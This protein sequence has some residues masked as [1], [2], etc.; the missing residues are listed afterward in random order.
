MSIAAKIILLYSLSFAVALFYGHRGPCLSLMALLTHAVPA[1]PLEAVVLG[2]VAVVAG[3]AGHLAAGLER[4][5]R[6][7]RRCRPVVHL[8]LLEP[9]VYRV[10]GYG[11]DVVDH[12]EACRQPR[13]ARR[14]EVPEP[15]R[16]SV[17]RPGRA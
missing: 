6:R 8:R 16:V 13:V 7:Y 5:P 15:G 2:A 10:P 4:H 14:A 12:G 9:E 11:R 3:D 17:E 1:Q